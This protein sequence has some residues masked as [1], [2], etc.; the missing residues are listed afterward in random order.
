MTRGL[1]ATFLRVLAVSAA[2]S[3][4]SGLAARPCPAAD[5]VLERVLAAEQARVELIQR[6]SPTVISV[7]QVHGATHD[8]ARGAGSGVIITPDGYALTNYHVTGAAEELRAGLPGG[9][10]LKARR[11]GVDPTGDVAVIKLESDD[12]LPCAELGASND[13][14]VGEWVIAMGNPFLLATDFR[15][16]VSMGVVSGVHRYLSGTGLFRQTLVYADAIQVDAALNPGNSG[17]P[18]FDLGG[19]LVG[20]NGRITIRR[21]EGMMIRRP[22]NMGVG[23][24]VPID[25][26]RPFLDDLKAGRDVDRG[27]LGVARVDPEDDGLKIT[28]IQPDSPAEIFDLRAGDVILA[29]DGVRLDDAG[30]MKNLTTLRPAG[31]RITV[32]LR[33]DKE[34]IERDVLLGG[35]Q[36]AAWLK[37]VE[38]RRG[39]RD[40]ASIL[41][42]PAPQAESEDQSDEDQPGDVPEGEDSEAPGQEKEQEQ[43]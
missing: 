22:T 28:K 33:R 15:P 23:F 7:F 43:P 41:R 24:A 27:F 14:V 30:E 8:L 34:R 42:P 2:V 5:E 35:I 40:E 37:S 29:I 9:R 17:G 16:T 1:R 11:C 19:R 21:V 18:L 12:P 20:I 10:I 13:L 38:M 32:E 26:I 36:T 6:L 31:T 4:I 25:A 3:S 39:V